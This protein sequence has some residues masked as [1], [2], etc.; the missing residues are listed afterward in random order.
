MTYSKVYIAPITLDFTPAGGDLIGGT[1]NGVEVNGTWDS[2]GSVKLYEGALDVSTYGSD[3]RQ[4][5]CSV[6]INDGQ[7]R[8]IVQSESAPTTNYELH[9]YRYAPADIV[10]IPQEYVEGLED[11]AADASEALKNVTTVRSTANAAKTAAETAQSTANAAKAAA[12]TAQS[13]AN[14]AAPKK[15]PEFTGTFSQNRE[16]GSV[17]G[18]FSHAEGFQTT[19]SGDRSHAEG[20]STTASGVDSHAE[21]V[22]S[23]ASGDR[24]HAEGSNTI[25]SGNH[26]HVQGVFNIE[27]T[28][29]KYAHIVGN[30]TGDETR[31]N[32]HTLD[33]YGNAWYEGTVEGT[34]MILPS[35]TPN[36]TKKFKITVDDIGAISATEVTT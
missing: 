8:I 1:V 34:A 25:A 22:S 10:Q 15:N 5:V 16:S 19:A 21:G 11:V 29:N 6:G 4:E 32:A 2:R 23:I 27:D 18:N 13:T 26:S 12:E 36:S 28:A 20:S 35:S 17:I 3:G 31:S 24:S 7:A 14:A 33:W 30:G 9:L